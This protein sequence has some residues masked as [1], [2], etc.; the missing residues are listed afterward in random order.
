PAG[1]ALLGSSTTSTIAGLRTYVNTVGQHLVPEQ[2]NN[3]GIGAEFAPTL[4]L[5]G[6]DVH[7]TWY[8][9]KINTVLAN[10]AKP[11]T[12]SFNV[13]SLGFSY[14]VP[15]D[16]A[17]LH[18]GADV[19]CHDNSRPAEPTYGCPEFEQIVQNILNFGRNAVPQ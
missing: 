13:S 11:T 9:I 19:R 1:L 10:Y 18:P 3:W 4:F 15:T 14:L 2:S 8:S 5:R 17:Y 16:L 6:L 7:A 12:H